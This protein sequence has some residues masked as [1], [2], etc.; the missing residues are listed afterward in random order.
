MAK[1][2]TPFNERLADQRN[3]H[4][5]SYRRLAEE[6]EKQGIPIT[7]TALRKWELGLGRNRIPDKPQVAALSRVF[8]VEP[9][10]LLEEM[11][12]IKPKGTGRSQHWQDLDLLTDDQ[13]DVL[14]AVK[15]QFLSIK[16]INTEGRNGEGTV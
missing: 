2:F 12:E 10:F 7:H 14:L 11:M 15:A 6:M 16:S 9:S 8:N 4:G 5:Y 1:K 3:A 13:H